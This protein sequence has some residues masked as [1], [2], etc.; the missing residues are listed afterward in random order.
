MRADVPGQG[1]LFPIAKHTADNESASGARWDFPLLAEVDAYRI[2]ATA[3]I[4]LRGEKKL[5]RIHLQPASRHPPE[6]W[7]DISSTGAG[8]TP[9]VSEF[10]ISGFWRR[11]RAAKTH[12][13]MP[14]LALDGF[15]EASRITPSLVLVVS[16]NRSVPLV[17]RSL[18]A[19]TDACQAAVTIGVQGSDQSS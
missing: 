15:R 14:V 13:W 8:D 4:H 6:Q 11:R 1:K 18:G 19:F 9:I 12:R 5:M 2:S 3:N 10:P 16:V 17:T 7:R